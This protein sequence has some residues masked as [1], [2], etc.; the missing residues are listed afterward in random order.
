MEYTTFNALGQWSL[1]KAKLDYN[2]FKGRKD[3]QLPKDV[4]TKGML[5]NTLR[6]KPHMSQHKMEGKVPTPKISSYASRNPSLE[7]DS[8]S[9]KIDNI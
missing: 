4:G 8:P 2:D 5:H 7:D 9:P 3:G 6:M 1:S